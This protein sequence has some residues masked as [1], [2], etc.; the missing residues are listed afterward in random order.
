MKRLFFRLRF[1]ALSAAR[2]LRASP[3]TSAVAVVTIALTL[4]LAGIFALLLANME[5]LLARAGADLHVT[6]W[7]EH[8]MTLEEQRTLM[9]TAAT[10]PGVEGVM[11][12]TEREAL[13][14]FE[15]GVGEALG[16]AD[17]LGENPLPA[18]LELTLVD[19]RRSAEGVRALAQELAKLPGVAEIGQGEQWVEGYAR[20]I[21]LARTVG[22]ALGAVLALATLL[23]V[24]NT[25]RLGIYARR[26]E[27]EILSLV[28]AGRTFVAIPFLAEGVL[29]GLLGGGVAALALY[30]LYRLA[31]PRFESGIQLFLGF[32]E[33]RFLDPREL[34][35]L[36]AAGALLGGLGSAAA[37]V[38]GWRR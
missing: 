34:A 31:L 17:A 3:V 9:E 14:R 38:Q 1:F 36:V 11:L 16:I 4:L 24:A 18:S 22:I 25:I 6:A 15:A 29:Q 37:L 26:D 21:D 30:A 28:G 2:G 32:A 7:L 10:L 35:V 12:T 13:A 8:G 23:I 20:A 19:G 33:P 27:I 5:D